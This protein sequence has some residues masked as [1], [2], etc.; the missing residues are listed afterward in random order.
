MW[1]P[2]DMRHSSTRQRRRREQRISRAR[3]TSKLLQ[4]P[5]IDDER[6]V[7]HFHNFEDESPIP[8]VICNFPAAASELDLI[9]DAVFRPA[10]H[11]MKEASDV[12]QG[13]ELGG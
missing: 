1:S 13:R 9:S 8:L 4:P 6:I 2:V 7:Q 5:F 3:A 12:F 10:Q 11:L